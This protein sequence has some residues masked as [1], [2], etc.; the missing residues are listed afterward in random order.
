L[1]NPVEHV[2]HIRLS[3]ILSRNFLNLDDLK[4]LYRL[5]YKSVS[6]SSPLTR[7]AYS[8][9]T[10]VWNKRTVEELEEDADCNSSQ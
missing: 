5:L 6:S 7:V 4:T 1:F 2:T 9:M 3:L 10:I 8:D